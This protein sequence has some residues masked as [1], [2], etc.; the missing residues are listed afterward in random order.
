MTHHLGLR[1]RLYPQHHLGP[2]RRLYPLDQL[3]PLGQSLLPRGRLLGLGD[4]FQLRVRRCRM[5]HRCHCLRRGN[6]GCHRRRNQRVL[7]DCHRPRQH[8]LCHRCHCRYRGHR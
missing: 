3:G 1:R 2:R 8:R 4:R 6:R 5:H 7:A